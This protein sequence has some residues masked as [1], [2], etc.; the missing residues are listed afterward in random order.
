MGNYVKIFLL[1]Q[2]AKGIS[3]V[4]PGGRFEAY[5]RQ[6]ENNPDKY[7]MDLKPLRPVNLNLTGDLLSNLEYKTI[8]KKNEK[9]IRFYFDGNWALIYEGN[10]NGQPDLNTRPR[11]VIPINEGEEFS[12]SA[13][14]FIKKRMKEV[15]NKAIEQMNKT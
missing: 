13:N 6:R 3:S 8:N 4:K 2:T 12:E 5:V 1:G 10:H 15:I 14:R 7:P 11:K 9:G